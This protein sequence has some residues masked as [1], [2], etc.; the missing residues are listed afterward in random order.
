[1][2]NE[3]RQNKVTKEWVIFAPSRGNRPHDHQPNPGT[4]PRS[5][6]YAASCPFCPGNEHLLPTVLAQWPHQSNGVWQTRVVCN[7]YPALTPDSSSDRISNGIYVQMPGYGHHE[8]IVESPHHNDD[9]ADLSL[10]E[11][12]SILTT[13][14]QRYVTHRQD[15]RN[16]LLLLFRNH[17]SRAGA[18]LTHPHSQL[19]ATGIIPR[20]IRW[21][22]D[23]AR[24]YFDEWGRCI[25]CDVIAFEAL[26][27]Q[28]V[29]L[30]TPNFLAFVPYAAEVPFETWI[31]PKRHHTD[32]EQITEEEQVDLAS[33]LQTFLIRLRDTLHDPDYNYIINSSIRRGADEY[34]HWYVRVRPRLITRAG[35]EIGSGIRINPSL[36]EADAAMLRDGKP[37]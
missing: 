29:I 35:F 32:F 2:T 20:H 33:I 25:Y 27:R 26:D 23:E 37:L 4:V 3:I 12:N 18:S 6:A 10:Q 14:R 24:Q 22:E 34:L 16:V 13:Y 8:V 5:A 9:L 11:M 1:M 15:S 21:Q 19:I 30:D 28:R 36:P 7:K 31:V 17:G